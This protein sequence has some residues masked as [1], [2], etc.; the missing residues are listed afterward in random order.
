M[1]AWKREKCENTPICRLRVVG[2][3]IV[4]LQKHLFAFALSPS[5]STP[6]EQT[7]PQWRTPHPPSTPPSEHAVSQR[8]LSVTLT[9][10]S[11]KRK[12]ILQ[13]KQT[14]RSSDWFKTFDESGCAVGDQPVFIFYPFLF[15]IYPFLWPIPPP[16]TTTTTFPPSSNASP[17]QPGWTERSI[18]AME[19]TRAPQ[20]RPVGRSDHNAVHLMP[21]YKQKV[22]T[23]GTP[24]NNLSY[25]LV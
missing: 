7:V 18:Y 11:S 4:M 2:L 23:E 3:S 6:R 25:E 19:T 1:S 14:E 24:K 5:P 13:S 10:Q 17:V 8:T 22:K 15:I 16:T 21:K 9:K 20:Y 12:T